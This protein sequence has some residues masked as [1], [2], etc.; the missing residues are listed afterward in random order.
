MAIDQ[1]PPGPESVEKIAAG[2]AAFFAGLIALARVWQRQ[3][4]EP[5]PEK[6][7]EKL[8]SAIEANTQAVQGVAEQNRELVAQ[9][10]M[11]MHLQTQIMTQVQDTRD[12]LIA[13]GARG[14]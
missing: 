7:A 9:L 11:N 12:R 14:S 1:I 10:K 4:P 6:G 8:L 13:L 2:A 5:A 3:T